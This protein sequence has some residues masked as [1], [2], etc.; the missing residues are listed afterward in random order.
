M[1]KLEC[2]N[3]SHTIEKMNNKKTENSFQLKL[4]INGKFRKDQPLK[5]IESNQHKMFKEALTQTLTQMMRVM[6]KSNL[7][8]VI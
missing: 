7:E 5:M 1:I 3:I 4:K 2:A 6:I 8:L